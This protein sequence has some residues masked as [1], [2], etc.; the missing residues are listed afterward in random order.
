MVFIDAQETIVGIVENATPETTTARKV[1]TP[2]TYV[3]EVNGGFCQ[4][5]GV[6]VGTKVEFFL[7]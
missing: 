4:K 1:D 5:H 3:L 2:S 6:K 7:H